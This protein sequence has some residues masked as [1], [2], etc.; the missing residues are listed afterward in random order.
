MPGNTAWRRPGLAA[1]DRDGSVNPAPGPARQG[2]GVKAMRDPFD[3][4]PPWVA[5]VAS[6]LAF[7]AR[8]TPGARRQRRALRQALRALRPRLAVPGGEAAA[9]AEFCAAALA[10]A[11]AGVAARPDL[12]AAGPALARLCALARA[13]LATDKD[14]RPLLAAADDA[15]PWPIAALPGRVVFLANMAEHMPAEA[16]AAAAML[17]N[18]LATLGLDLPRLA[19]E[20]AS[21]QPRSLRARQAAMASSASAA[22]IT[23]A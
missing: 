17:V 21:G 14:D 6:R 11:Q 16:P 23:S 22:S 15:L 10:L 13:A 3:D 19:L 18:D 2:V 9:L 7:F 1:A 20:A 8:A 4:L 12:H 5:A